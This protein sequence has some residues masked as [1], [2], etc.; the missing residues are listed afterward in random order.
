MV[1]KDMSNH[2]M[3]TQ[4]LWGNVK[5]QVLT[6]CHAKIT[7]LWVYWVGRSTK[8]YCWIIRWSLDAKAGYTALYSMILSLSCS[9]FEQISPPERDK[10]MGTIVTRFNEQVNA[11]LPTS[12]WTYMPSYWPLANLTCTLL[13]IH[14]YKCSPKLEIFCIENSLDLKKDT[15]TNWCSQQTVAFYYWAC[16]LEM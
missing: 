8:S 6:K 13:N 10:L 5:L 2:P 15:N 3:W 4:I 1:Y 11:C 12:V 7:K 16:L 9:F 14:Q